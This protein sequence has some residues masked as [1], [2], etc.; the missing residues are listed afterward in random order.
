MLKGRLVVNVP[1][2]PSD[3]LWYGFRDKPTLRVR[4]QPKFGETMVTIPKVL[5]SLEKKVLLEFQVSLA[6]FYFRFFEE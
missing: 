1:P 3:R 2:P 4:L 5:E 6:E